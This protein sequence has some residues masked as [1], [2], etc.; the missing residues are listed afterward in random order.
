MAPADG[1][2][3]FG[4]ELAAEIEGL[5]LMGRAY[6]GDM[7]AGR[8][9]GVEGTETQGIGGELAV[10]AVVGDRLV[11][12]GEGSALI[13]DDAG[14]VGGE[15]PRGLESLAAGG[16]RLRRARGRHVGGMMPD[17]GRM[18]RNPR[19]RAKEH[20]RWRSHCANGEHAR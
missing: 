6:F 1:F 18:P 13:D 7:G 9:D 2:G 20:L 16:G 11:V 5:L 10:A 8:R 17:G 19:S 3:T 14:V 12:V 15:L 4:Q